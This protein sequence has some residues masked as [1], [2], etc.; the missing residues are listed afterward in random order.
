MMGSMESGADFRATMS[1][2]NRTN[3]N[4]IAWRLCHTRESRHLHI[5][6]IL[7]LCGLHHKGFASCGV[8]RAK[9]ITAGHAGR[10]CTNV[11]MHISAC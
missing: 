8:Q 7:G 1:G 3:S 4:D 10:T 6:H 11:R 2:P 9:F 5:R